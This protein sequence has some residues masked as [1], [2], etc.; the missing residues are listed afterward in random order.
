VSSQLAETRVFATF[1]EQE[2]HGPIL[3][4]FFLSVFVCRLFYVMFE[5]FN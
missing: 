3:Y 2:P 1:Q 5:P 4:S